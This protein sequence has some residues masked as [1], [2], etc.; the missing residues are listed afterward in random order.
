VVFPSCAA[1]SLLFPLVKGDGVLIV[2][3]EVGIGK[4]MDSKVTDTVD[5]DDNSRFSITDAIAIPGLM[6]TPAIP[7]PP[8]LKEDGTALVSADGAV[9]EL[10]K[11]VGVRNSSGDLRT[12]LEKLWQAIADGF[13]DLSDKLK[14]LA[15]TATAAS[16]Y[17]TPPSVLASDI[18]SAADAAKSAQSS[19]TS[20]KDGPGKVFE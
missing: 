19:A 13:G 12:E 1:G 6:S 9:L 4:F 3:G 14:A 16:A 18:T 20:A 11:K 7:T 5:P 17:G 2:F 8:E 10:G 15:T